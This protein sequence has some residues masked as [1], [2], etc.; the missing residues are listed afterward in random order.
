[1]LLTAAYLYGTTISLRLAAALAVATPLADRLCID[2]R[3]V[4]LGPGGEGPRPDRTMLRGDQ[5]PR[6]EAGMFISIRIF[7]RRLPT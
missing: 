5:Q 3:G 6:G 7:S 2:T 4:P 1:M